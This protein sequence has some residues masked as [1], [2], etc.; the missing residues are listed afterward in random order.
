VPAATRTDPLSRR[1]R[2]IVDALYAIGEGGAREIAA[3]MRE[4]QA[5]DSV[6]VTLGVLERKGR[7]RHRVEGRRHIYAP[8]QPP[9]QARRSAWARLTRTFFGGSPG[10]ALITF[11]DLSGD[12]LDDAEL[13]ELSRWVADQTRR[14]KRP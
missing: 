8:V 12:R 6:R 14:R 1:E 13:D 4:P 5:L 3:A 2:Q 10:R 9:E 7:V 11:L